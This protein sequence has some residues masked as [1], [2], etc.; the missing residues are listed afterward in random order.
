DPPVPY[1]PSG[2][3]ESR[4]SG[5]S[6]HLH[7]G[8]AAQPGRP[9]RRRAHRHA[10]HAR[11]AG[12]HVVRRGRRRIRRLGELHRGQ[13]A[14]GARP[15]GLR[16]RPLHP[17][18]GR[19]HHPPE[20]AGPAGH[21]PGRRAPGGLLP[22]RH[23]PVPEVLRRVTARR[24]DRGRQLHRRC[25]AGGGREPSARHC[26]PGRGPGRQAV[27]ARGAGGRRRGQPGQQPD[28]LRGRRTEG[29]PGSD[30]ARQDE[31]RLLP[32]R[33]PSRQPAR[34]P[35][36]VHR[37]EHQPHQARVPPDQAQPRRLLLHHR[38]RGPRRRRGGGRLPARPAG[39]AGQREVPGLLPGGRRARPRRPPRRRGG[40]EG[41]GRV[42]R[43]P[44]QAGGPL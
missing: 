35:R 34:H 44:A 24:G 25:G 22:C 39:P 41:G 27:R 19:P 13:R 17:A 43:E 37:P 36:P 8:G 31:H 6:W 5:P 10:L 9:G 15:A 2:R 18:G 4:L 33:R 23:G 11:S 38:P 26:R 30:R 16:P 14:G 29:H 12:R 1:G 42:D 28:P 21:G 3:S 40:V 32:A 20:P 7:R